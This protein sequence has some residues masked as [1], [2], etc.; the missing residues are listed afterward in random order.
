MFCKFGSADAKRPVLVA[1][2]KKDVWIRLVF[3]SIYSGRV[4]VYVFFNLDFCLH[5]KTNFGNSCPLLAKSSRTFTFVAKFPFLV[6]FVPEIFN[7]SYKISPNCL[8][9]AILNSSPD[10]L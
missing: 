8:V 1:A 7:F 2:S 10:S 3:L 6:F 4:S 9:E 5:S